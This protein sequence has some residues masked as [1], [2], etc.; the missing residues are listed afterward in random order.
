[1]ALVAG[2]MVIGLAL[3]AT[4]KAY[5]AVTEAPVS[6]RTGPGVGYPRIVVLPAGAQ[7]WVASCVPSWC[8]V[9]WR[10]V[11]GWVARSY[12]ARGYYDEPYY[13]DYYDY[14]DYWGYPWYWDDWHH[15]HKPP[16][17]HKPPHGPKP[18]DGP[19]WSKPPKGN[20]PPNW[21]DHSGK[22][23]KKPDDGGRVIGSDR[24]DRSNDLPSVRRSDGPPDGGPR[25]GGDRG[26]RDDDDRWKRD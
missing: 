25:D 4:A 7:V 23:W 8:R 26:P 18:P 14:P 22:G 2:A 11:S 16:K 13:D 21:P 12:L 3:P 15:H 5:Y 9:S 20:P 6:L 19:K 24:Q 1:M 10:N 17:H